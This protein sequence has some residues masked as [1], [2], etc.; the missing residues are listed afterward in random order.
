M[1]RLLSLVLFLSCLLS[2]VAQTTAMPNDVTLTTGRVLRNVKV[3]RWEKDRVVLRHAGGVDPVA[4]V[5]FKIPAPEDLP[6]I[7][8]ASDASPKPGIVAPAAGAEHTLT[9]QVLTTLRGSFKFAN[10]TVRAYPASEFDAAA[11]REKTKLPENFH[12]MMPPD[13]SAA[14]AR[15][16]PEALTG[17]TVV[18]EAVTDADG[19]YSMTL[20]PNTEIFLLCTAI[21]RTVHTVEQYTWVVHLEMGAAK[22]DLSDANRFT[23]A[24]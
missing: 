18:A 5:L 23:Q 1:K 16:W 24:E 4:F 12:S 3:L 17:V 10:V 6:A 9:G 21:R 20:P 19:H 2:A 7:R 15:A 11:A 13:R 22:L 8:A 14:W